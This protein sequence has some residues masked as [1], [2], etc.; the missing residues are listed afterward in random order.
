MSIS[1]AFSSNKQCNIF[2]L[3]THW[4]IVHFYWHS[5]QYPIYIY[6]REKTCKT[7]QENYLSFSVFDVDTK[8]NVFFWLN[9]W[10][11]FFNARFQTFVCTIL[12]T[13]MY[14]GLTRFHMSKMKISMY[15][16]M[17]ITDSKLKTFSFS[18]KLYLTRTTHITAT[19]NVDKRSY[20]T[21][22][23]FQRILYLIELLDWVVKLRNNISFFWHLECYITEE[24]ITKY[25]IKR[26]KFRST[27]HLN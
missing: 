17:Y 2:K 7:F 3:V 13:D 8:H 6:C 22:M 4:L 27:F 23:N 5:L 9:A 24:T 20:F 10:K 18:R 26:M 12:F 14:S 11:I 15:M 21:Y 1:N 19:C 16:S 25:Q